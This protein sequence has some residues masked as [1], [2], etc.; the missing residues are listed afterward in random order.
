MPLAPVVL[1][2]PV[3]EA[4]WSPGLPTGQ[5]ELE[6]MSERQQWWQT[7][8][9]GTEWKQCWGDGWLPW[10]LQS[11]G[12]D[13]AIWAARLGCGPWRVEL[14]MHS[15]LW[16]GQGSLRDWGCAQAHYLWLLWLGVKAMAPV[17]RGWRKKLYELGNHW[18]IEPRRCIQF[19]NVETMH[20][21]ILLMYS[22]DV[23][24]FVVSVGDNKKDMSFGVRQ[25]GS[26]IFS[27]GSMPYLW[28]L[29][30]VS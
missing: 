29:G 5:S 10:V 22:R 3:G 2:L 9:R 18:A 1:S 28:D 17:E 13:A 24:I 7:G 30:K 14:C 11:G 26:P 12:D 15:A 6:T 4:L 27:S 25:M 20:W 19:F 21:A 23:H 16:M 8:E